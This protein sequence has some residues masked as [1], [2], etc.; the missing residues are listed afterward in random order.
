[1]MRPAPRA[2]LVRTGEEQRRPALEAELERPGRRRH[3]LIE[4][5]LAETTAA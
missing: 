1:M 4:R 2:L 3:P 5:H